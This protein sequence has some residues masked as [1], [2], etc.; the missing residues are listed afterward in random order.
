MTHEET[1]ERYD[2]DAEDIRKLRNQGHRAPKARIPM[3][4]AE[5]CEG[6]A[7]ELNQH[8]VDS[9][10]D[11][12]GIVV[13]E[14]EPPPPEWNFNLLLR[15]PWKCQRHAVMIATTG[16]RKT[17]NYQDALEKRIVAVRDTDMDRSGIL[18]ITIDLNEEGGIE[19]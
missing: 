12:S 16:E 5:E 19:K 4:V 9:D 1:K 13:A 3:I 10:T 18:A 2:K 17:G 8:Y 11:L 15:Q 6:H 14:I 7:D